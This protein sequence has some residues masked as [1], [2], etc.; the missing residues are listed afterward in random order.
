MVQLPWAVQAPPHKRQLKRLG[1]HSS[2][3]GGACTALGWHGGNAALSTTSPYPPPGRCKH[4]RPTSTTTPA[5][6]VGITRVA[7]AQ[8]MFYPAILP[9][10]L[11][12][13]LLGLSQ[14]A[15]SEGLHHLPP[16][17]RG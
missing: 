17:V 8:S 9:V 7:L 10:S 16:G 12:A 4:P 11:A 6:T 14:S 1:H 13:L 5:P 15:A 3:G 2:R